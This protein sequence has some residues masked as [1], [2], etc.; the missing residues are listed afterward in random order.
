MK[1]IILIVLGVLALVLGGVGIFLPVWPTTPFVL[2]AAGCFGASSP[3]LYR[4]LASTQYFGEYIQNYKSKT[5]ISSKTRWTGIVFL[6]LM[7]GISS[8]IFRTWYI[9]I[10]LGVV[11]IAVTVHILMIR[12]KKQD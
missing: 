7:L 9:W 2:C 12:R 10:I 5:G 1:Q 3:K 11:G 4:K 6:W 8:L